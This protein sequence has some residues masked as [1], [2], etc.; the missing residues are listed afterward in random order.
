[1]SA[2]GGSGRAASKEEVRVRPQGDIGCLS[3]E[4][5]PNSQVSQWLPMLRTSADTGL[6]WQSDADDSIRNDLEGRFRA[7]KSQFGVI[8]S[9]SSA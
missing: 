4:V 5:R 3:D 1:M 2:L 6:Q 9:G 8:T 7:K